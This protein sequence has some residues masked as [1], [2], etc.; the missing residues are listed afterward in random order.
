MQECRTN[1]KNR[2]GKGRRVL[3]LPSLIFPACNFQIEVTDHRGSGLHSSLTELLCSKRYPGGFRSV[4]CWN[5]D[6]SGRAV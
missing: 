5:A 3:S 4:S 2:H 1:T 6:S